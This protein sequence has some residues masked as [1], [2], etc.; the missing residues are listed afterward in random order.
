MF[1][2]TTVTYEIHFL[3]KKANT[4]IYNLAYVKISF[5]G[6]ITFSVWWYILINISISFRLT[7]EKLQVMLDKSK[8][9]TQAHPRVNMLFIWKLN[10]NL[11]RLQRTRLCQEA[12]MLPTSQTVVASYI[13][14]TFNVY[15]L[16]FYKNERLFVYLPFLSQM[17]RIFFD[18]L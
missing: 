5:C 9:L 13:Y 1:L 12:V 3:N 18:T 2:Y 10:W 6:E 16:T 7:S 15:I 4:F 8:N 17:S 14:S 11:T